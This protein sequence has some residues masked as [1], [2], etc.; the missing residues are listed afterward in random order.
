[1]SEF[2]R[3]VSALNL[4]ALWTCAC[5]AL[6]VF[7]WML[8]SIA[9]FRRTPAEVAQGRGMSAEV[10]WALVP[11]AVVIAMA[12][13]A[14]RTMLPPQQPGATETAQQPR[15]TAAPALEREISQKPFHEGAIPL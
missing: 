4:T 7:A 3:Y 14:I 13:P 1:M 11:I 5:I 8:Y 10:L 2:T 6:V 15:A 12:L 9:T